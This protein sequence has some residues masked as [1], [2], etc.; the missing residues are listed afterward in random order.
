M[1]LLGAVVT[2]TACQSSSQASLKT[3]SQKASYALGVSIGTQLKPSAERVDLAALGKGLDD[4]MSGRDL[5]IPKDSLQKILQDFSKTA[6][7]DR[8]KARVDEGNKNLKAGKA[9]MDENG[10]KPGVKTT[11]SGLQYEVLQPGDGPHPDSADQVTVQYKGT[12]VDGTEFDSSYKR[13]QPATFYVNRVIKGFSEGLQLMP[14]GSKYRFV[15]PPNLAYGPQGSG[16]AI[17]PDETLVFE[18]EL[19]KIDSAGTSAGGGS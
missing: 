5:A 17:G 2:V 15:I 11:D 19:V 9:F 1:A 6:Q 10:K 3:D 4:A 12:L 16:D 7:D 14:V 13:G 8:I 18:V